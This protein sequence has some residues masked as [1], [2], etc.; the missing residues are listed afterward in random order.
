MLNLLAEFHQSSK[1]PI[2]LIDEHK[3]ITESY[4]L[5]VTPNFPSVYIRELDKIIYPDIRIYMVNTTEYFSVISTENK[6]YHYIVLWMNNYTIEQTGYYQDKFPTIGVERL[7]SYTKVL[8]F[9]LFRKIPQIS[10][11]RHITNTR[12]IADQKSKINFTNNDTQHNGYLEEKFMLN[13]IEN[14]NLTDF[15]NK[16]RKLLQSGS[17]GLMVNGNEIRNKKDLALA[18]TALITRS[19]IRGGLLPNYAFALSDKCCQRIESMT[20]IVSVSNLIQE[21]GTLFIKQIRNSTKTPNHDIVYKVQDY[22]QQH[23][24][25]TIH[26]GSIAQSIGYSKSRLC[27]IYKAESGKT[28]I[29][30]TNQL[31]IHEVESELIFSQNSIAEIADNLGFSDQSYLTRMFTKYKHITPRAY[32]KKYHI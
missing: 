16:L 23:L 17:F 2:F 22:I 18:A 1:L 10:A 27:T 20:T 19:A 11:P 9:A 26:L 28:I 15:N 24:E 21:I 29:Q 25:E 3:K 8:Y 14:A 4:R 31:K 5:T 32:Q 12:F 30:Y 7:V 6:N 13:A